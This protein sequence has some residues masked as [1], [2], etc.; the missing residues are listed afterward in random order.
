MKTIIKKLSE[1]RKLIASEKN[2]KAGKNNF[3]NY[4]YFTPEQVQSIV[5]AACEKC[6][7]LPL[8]SLVRDD[9]GV[10][11]RLSIYDIET[12]EAITFEMATAIPEIKATNAAQQLG[13]CMTYTERYL[14]MSAFGIKDNSLDFD[15]DSNSPAKPSESPQEKQTWMPKSLF[16]DY[17]EK[18]ESALFIEDLN[19]IAAKIKQFKDNGGMVRKEYN[20]KLTAL[21]TE[22]KKTL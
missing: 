4:N 1:A 20:E 17:C 7:I 15:S 3:A 9:L 13:G 18:I 21:F 8:F 12:A 2:Q 14:Q 22:K 11:G 10:K 19:D 5:Q 16:E 6:Q